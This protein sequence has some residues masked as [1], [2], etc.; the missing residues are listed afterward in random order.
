MSTARR[1]TAAQVDRRAF[2]L[3]ELL[4]VIAII[5]LLVVLLLPAVN[6][7]RA[8]ARRTQCQ[9]KLK[10]LGIALH[11]YAGANKDR[12]PPG[13]PGNSLQGLFSYLLPYLEEEQVYDQLDLDKTVQ[14]STNEKQNPLRW[15]SVP[16]YVCPSYPYPTIVRNAA[17]AGYKQGALTTYQ[18]IAGAHIRTAD[19]NFE[20]KV[21]PSPY[22]DIPHN[23][24]FGW[25]FERRLNQIKDGLS[26]TIAV[27]EFVHRDF[28]DSQ[29]SEPPGNV[30]AWILGANNNFGSYSVKVAEFPPN[31]RI[32]R[33]ADGVNYN[34][35]P[36]GSHH[37]GIT[38]FVMG[39]GSVRGIEDEIDLAVF[40]GMTTV[41]GFETASELP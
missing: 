6:A 32:D 23:G 15:Y 19:P 33:I 5:G 26:K 7:T 2:T 14:H 39:D 22:G 29:F 31:T 1:S 10:Q 27:G 13:C 3:V 40:Q 24:M 37:I 41:A 21:T 35:L 8:A 16:T 4:V 25:E 30:R 38:F 9:N 11:G 36:T 28:E 17:L 18:G 12:M 20:Q 34:H